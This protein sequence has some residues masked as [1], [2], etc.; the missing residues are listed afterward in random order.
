MIYFIFIILFL[1]VLVITAVMFRS[2]NLSGK[3]KKAKQLL[4]EGQL[5][6]SSKLV[7]GV[8]DK[9]KDNVQARYLRAQILMQEKQY[10]MAISELNGLLNMPDLKQFISETEI[11]YNLAEMYNATG[12]FKKEIE[13]YRIILIFKPDDIKA[14]LR[15]GLA[16]Y[17]RKDY[18][19]AK[20][21][22]M[23]TA[24]GEPKQPLSFLPLG[25]SLLK[26]KEY[27]NA[28]EWLLKALEIDN[29][30][31]EAK[32]HLGSLF[33]NKKAYE[34]AIAMLG[35]SKNDPKFYLPSL[36][37]IGEMYF[38]Q[39][40]YDK[41]IETLEPALKK[42]S[43]PL[44]ESLALRYLLASCYESSGMLREAINQWEIIFKNDSDYRDTKKN[45][46]N[47]K[48]IMRNEQLMEMFSMTMEELQPYIADILLGFNYNII[49]QG[50]VSANEY[51]YK[52]YN[53]KRISAPPTVIVFD[54]T[55]REIDD[56]QLNKVEAIMESEK[57]KNGIYM[58]TGSFSL[59]VRSLAPT[60][61]IELYD[62]IFLS[63]A[64]EKMKTK[65]TP[66]RKGML[67]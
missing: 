53:M 65:N 41:A 28:E 51:K 2:S 56:T 58:T 15:L 43:D 12:N 63:K 64:I 66:K 36:M 17:S 26:L 48:N 13:E 54:R 44:P 59:K 42:T 25:V 16:L 29:E 27:E 35:Q 55:T 30:N 32:F 10:L 52:A 21:H 11:H 9:Q 22:L 62:G 18:K 7:R 40:L 61:Q 24:Q 37:Q 49:S 60:K 20:I 14:N 34:S 67:K 23:K 8:L 47:Y 39:E 3:L 1:C 19:G 38:E 50:H 4:D 46:D 57:C 6:E 33:K 45:L 31:I 5:S